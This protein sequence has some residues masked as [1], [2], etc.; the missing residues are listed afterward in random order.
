MCSDTNSPHWLR[1][2]GA[3]LAVLLLAAI[4]ACAARPVLP[5]ALPA[6]LRYPEFV[7]P[8]V[9]VA[10][11][12][13]PGALQVEFGW[14]YLQNDD[15]RGAEREFTAAARR[16]PAF[17]PARTGEGYVALARRNYE[18]A[19]AAF[20]A[21]LQREE[22]YVPALVG[23]GQ[24][25]LELNRDNDALASFEAAVTAD[26]SLTDLRRRID[27]L[28]FRNVQELIEE[29]RRAVDA[30]RFD[31]AR[32]AYDRALA[33]SPDSAFLHRELGS[34]E[35]RRGNLDAALEHLRRA[36]E[37]DPGD[38][39]AL[40]GIA[41]TL[42]QQGDF[43]G[44]EAAYRKAASIDP[45]PDLDA[46]IA[47]AAA[48]A[49]EAALPAEFHAIPASPAITRGDLAALLAVRFEDLLR[50]AP[51]REVVITDGASHWAASWI[52]EVAVAG[53]MDPYDNHTFQPQAGVRRGDLAA[54]VTRILTL[55]SASD[56]ALRK[57]LAERPV[58]ADMNA[59]HLA[60]PAAAVAV[61]TGVM[62][63]LE[64]G[65]FQVSRPVTGQEAID[66][67]ARL[68]ALR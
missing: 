45:G 43:A 68:R 46:R 41:E 54:A 1:R 24:A 11:R 42:D 25:L 32:V 44:A 14:R 47:A 62:P 26:P 3:P 30:G 10:L 22:A 2:L 21:A 15:L 35:R 58:I 52:T 12:Q 36:N 48:K 9:P 18:Q 29:A 33:A 65:R 67:I 40:I 64:G 56:P 59:A 6:T 37:L 57:R 28:R 66:V 20:D 39:A 7:F 8:F 23:R 31:E 55:L 61:A 5:P 4:S 34:V 53:V 38:A 13:T 27:V 50:S 19:V 63:L 60:Y 17:Y 16:D 49:R 51:R